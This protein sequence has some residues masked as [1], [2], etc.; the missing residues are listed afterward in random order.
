MKRMTV[1]QIRRSPKH[2]RASGLAV[3]A[4]GMAVAAWAGAIGLATGLLDLIAPI[5]HRLPFSSPV[6]GGV[7]LALIV[8]VPC[9]ATAWF[10]WRGDERAARVGEVAGWLLIAWIAVEVAFIRSFSVL[11]PICTGVGMLIVALGKRVGR[12]PSPDGGRRR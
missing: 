1:L 4:A 11:Q 2:A 9:T 6:F 12:R 10:A 7:A 8:A 3:T 5:E